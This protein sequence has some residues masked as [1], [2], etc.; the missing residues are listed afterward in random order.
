MVNEEPDNIEQAAEPGDDENDM[1]RLYVIVHYM[2][3]LRS[4]SLSGMHLI[5]P[6]L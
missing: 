5:W 2:D 6:D 3:F 1:Q 4:S